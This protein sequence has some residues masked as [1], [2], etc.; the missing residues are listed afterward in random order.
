MKTFRRVQI[1]VR[2][3]SSNSKNDND[4]GNNSYNF[5]IN[6]KVFNNNNDDNNS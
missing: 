1:Q 3:K 4:F 6:I 2:R 5:L